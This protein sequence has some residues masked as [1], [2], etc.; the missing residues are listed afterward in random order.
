MTEQVDFAEFAAARRVDLLKFAMV[1]TGNSYQAQ[2]VVSAVFARAFEQ[3]G[4]IGVMDH[5]QAYVRRMIVNEHLSAQRHD[6][7]ALQ[8]GHEMV[9]V[10][11]VGPDP[12]D[13]VDERQ[14]MVS[15]LEKLTPHQRTAVVLRYYLDMNDA[16]IADYLG[17]GSATVRSHLSHALAALRID[18]SKPVRREETTHGH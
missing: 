9:R 17:C 6:A 5:A 11:L 4:R 10:S 2:E 12:A 14:A 1:L 16:E 7:V 15:R 8:A 13:S 3:W 18:L